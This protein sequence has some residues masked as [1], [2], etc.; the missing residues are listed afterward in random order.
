M[1]Y[2]EVLILLFATVLPFILDL[3][4][5]KLNHKPLSILL[6]GILTIHLIFEGV[7]WQL[8][9]IYLI[10]LICIFLISKG[11]SY[12]KGGWLL[13]TLNGILLFFMLI[14]GFSFATVLPIFDL[15]T[16]KGQY[17]VGVRYIHVIS[18]R[19]EH[20]TKKEGDK[21]EF[22]VKV[23]YPSNSL[24]SQREKYLDE[25]GRKGIAIK[26]N[27][28]E[29]TFGYL[30]KIKT[31]TFQ[32]PDFAAGTFPVLIFSHGYYSNAFGYYALIEDIVSQGFIVININHTYESVGSKFPSGEVKFYDKEYDK[33]H[34]D[35]EMASMIWKATEDLKKATN[36]TE[37]QKAI[38]YILKNY[39]AS[40]ISERWEKDIHEVVRQIPQWSE[41]T[42]LANHID[43]SKI[44][45]L[46]H[47]QGG[48][49]VGQALIDNPKITAGINIDGVQW[50]AM[51]DTSLNKP[52]LLLSSD[53]AD[54]HPDF[55][56]IAYHKSGS[57][58]FYLAEIKNSGHSNFMDIPFMVNL[59]LLNESGKINP[60]K[61]IR[62]TSELVVKFFNK[63]LNNVETD[64]VKLPNLHPE[65]E[66]ML[67]PMIDNNENWLQQGVKQQ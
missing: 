14:L 65:L 29:N 58:N 16:P 42:F 15:P 52:F 8:V 26:Y 5:V 23:W 44:G 54:D 24:E 4:K 48:S 33:K 9:P 62:I 36:I 64:L 46:G 66:I 63:Y 49:A 18:D 1:R 11:Y 40:K 50:G 12:F 37:K 3:K 21:R 67:K 55:N 60:T 35:E 31:N 7:R 53:W 30:D 2:L 22:M 32:E 10:Y 43:T 27:L 56:Q 45:V 61:A 38:D 13:R 57:N 6:I 39:I 20:I 17:K 25:G 51:V 34:N 41:T 59:P 28:P 19:D 47:S